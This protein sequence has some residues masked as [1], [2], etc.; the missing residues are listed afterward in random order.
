LHLK[1]LKTVIPLYDCPLDQDE[2]ID[3]I[4][5]YGENNAHLRSISGD[6]NTIDFPDGLIGPSK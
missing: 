6:P 3:I 1:K 5:K 4:I 2:D